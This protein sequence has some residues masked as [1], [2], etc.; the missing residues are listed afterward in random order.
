MN[1][2]KTLFWERRSLKKASTLSQKGQEFNVREKTQGVSACPSLLPNVV[3]VAT[4]G[5]FFPSL[6]PSAFI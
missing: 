4:S 1:R 6:W 2:L 3:M 5:V